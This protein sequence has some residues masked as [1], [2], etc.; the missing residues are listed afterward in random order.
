MVR[1]WRSVFAIIAAIMLFVMVLAKI[2]TSDHRTLFSRSTAKTSLASRLTQASSN[3]SDSPQHA[4]ADVGPLPFSL[5]LNGPAEPPGT[6][7]NA[8]DA[9]INDST[10]TIDAADAEPPDWEARPT[11]WFPMCAPDP[12]TGHFPCMKCLYDEQCQAGQGCL[13]NRETQQIECL[14]SNCKTDEDCTPMGAGFEC[15]VASRDERVRRCVEAG[16]AKEGKFCAVDPWNERDSCEEGFVC[17]A[18]RC[19]KR[20]IK[21]KVDSCPAGQQCVESPNGA[22]CQPL[23]CRSVPCDAGTCERV[24]ETNFACVTR[25]LGPNCFEQPCRHGEQCEALEADGIAAFSC[26]IPCTPMDADSCPKG[27]V[28]GKSRTSPTQSVCYAGCKVDVFSC[29][30]HSGCFTVSEDHSLRG[31][32]LDPFMPDGLPEQTAH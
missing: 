8:A 19:S 9:A 4:P 12:K 18:K 22:A 17:L 11:D 5:H 3:N 16:T 20:C 31:C 6:S 1:D 10:A 28:C 25:H 14:S 27:D 15:R 30:P 21:G 7:V 32:A 2:F 26:A 29:G 23:D 13:V 24:G